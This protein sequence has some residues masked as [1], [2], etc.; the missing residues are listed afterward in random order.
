FYNGYY[1]SPQS[2]VTG[3]PGFYIRPDIKVRMVGGSAYYVFNHRKFSYRAGL[4]QNEWQTKSAGTFLLGGDIFYGTVNSDSLLVPQEI[5]NQ[6]P[7]GSVSRMRFI[8]IGPGAGYAY[9]F[10]YKRNWFA[11]G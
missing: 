2:F 4:I 11:T 8:N 1:V 10:V 6:F 7:Q 3:F 9:T 5:A